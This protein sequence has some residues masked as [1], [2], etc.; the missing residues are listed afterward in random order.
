MPLAARLLVKCLTGKVMPSERAF[1]NSG[2]VGIEFPR[3]RSARAIGVR[4]VELER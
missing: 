1:D 4:R 3:Q 2:G